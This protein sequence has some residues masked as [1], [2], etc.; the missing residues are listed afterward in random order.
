MN[1]QPVDKIE[2]LRVSNTG[3]YCSSDRVGEVYNKCSENSTVSI[4]ALCNSCEDRDTLYS[5][6]DP[7]YL[8]NHEAFDLRLQLPFISCLLG[9]CRISL[10]K[11][12]VGSPKLPV[13]LGTTVITALY[14]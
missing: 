9:N 3:I 2:I 8:D 5:A 10:Q 14:T 11:T 13:G 1:V 4:N 12:I 6:S 7:E